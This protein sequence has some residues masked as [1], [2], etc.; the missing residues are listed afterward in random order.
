MFLIFRLVKSSFLAC[1]PY[2]WAVLLFIV[3]ISLGSCFQV[4]AVSTYRYDGSVDGLR[5][6]LFDTKDARVS[7]GLARD[8]YIAEP[9]EFAGN[10]LEIRGEGAR[11]IDLSGQGGLRLNK[12]Q[13]LDLSDLEFVASPSRALDCIDQDC[14]GIFV[15]GRPGS[16]LKVALKNVSV[17]GAGGHGIHVRADDSNVFLRSRDSSIRSVGWSLS[18]RDGIRVDQTGSGSIQWHDKNSSFVGNG[19]DGVELDEAGAGGVKVHL[20]GSVFEANGAYFFGRSG[21]EGFADV[22]EKTGFDLDDGFDIDEEGDGDVRAVLKRVRVLSNFDEGIDFDELNS[23]LLSVEIK[24]ST[25]LSWFDES[26]S[27]SGGGEAADHCL[28]VNV[29]SGPVDSLPDGCRRLS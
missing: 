11:I 8:V 5:R 23:G 19:G 10:S 18:D 1:K 13:S 21:E 24:D 6:Y 20:S 14:S 4:S 7:I 29:V 27:L 12:V 22:S 25:V 3:L 17:I 15:S 9:L 16:D 28:L 26:I 2:V